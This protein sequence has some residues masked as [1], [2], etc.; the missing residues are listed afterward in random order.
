VLPVVDCDSSLLHIVFVNLLSNAL[1]YSRPRD[2]AVITIGMEVQDRQT[3]VFVRD[4]GVGFDPRYQ[5]KLFGV[6]SF[7]GNAAACA[8]RG[9]S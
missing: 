9:R 7:S 5:A 3:I 8:T 1:K 2:V 6:F 4:N